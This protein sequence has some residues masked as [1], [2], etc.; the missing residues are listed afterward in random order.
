[1]DITKLPVLQGVVL[2]LF[3]AMGIG[4][5]GAF[6]A[7]DDDNGEA[8]NDNGAPTE[9]PANG[10][11]PPP[12]GTSISMGDN[13][14]DPSELT[15][16]AGETVT[17]SLTNDGSAI[18]NMRIAGADNQYD[19]DDDAVSD[20]DLFTAGTTGTIEWT[21]PDSPGTYD[22]RCDFH[23]TDMVGTITVQ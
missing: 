8:T 5:Y 12:G 7:T 17:Y 16:A 6:M 18:H 21:V 2:F 13:F 1:M 9:T 4:F 14:F 3:V 10:A 15:L 11:T 19:T 22:F 20:P 23:P